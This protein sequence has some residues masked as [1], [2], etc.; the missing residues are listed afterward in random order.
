MATGCSL[1]DGGGHILVAR[2]EVEHQSVC[3]ALGQLGKLDKSRSDIFTG[4]L[5]GQRLV[6]CQGNPARATFVEKGAGP[7]DSPRERLSLR[8]ILV[9]VV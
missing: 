6:D 8:K 9:G 3:L 2:Q 4:N 1:L 5:V 7:E